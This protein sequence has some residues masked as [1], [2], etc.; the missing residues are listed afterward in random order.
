MV[1]SKD[2]AKDKIKSGTSCA[3]RQ[4]KKK[5]CLKNDE[6]LSKGHRN[7]FEGAPNGQIWDDMSKK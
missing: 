1:H 6:G 5:K 4:L 2:K 7:K 3:A